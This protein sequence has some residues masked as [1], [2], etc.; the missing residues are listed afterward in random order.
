MLECCSGLHCALVPHTT[1]VNAS[2]MQPSKHY[3]AQYEAFLPASQ[4]CYKVVHKPHLIDYTQLVFPVQLRVWQGN[5]W[6]E[7][8]RRDEGEIQ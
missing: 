1:S 6:G 7:R 4:M 2:K 3:R 8:G 5:R